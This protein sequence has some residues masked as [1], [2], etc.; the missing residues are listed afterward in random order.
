MFKKLFLLLFILLLSSCAS[1]IKREYKINLP[2]V[3]AGEKVFGV[4]IRPEVS[5]CNRDRVIELNPEWIRTSI[6]WAEVEETKGTYTWNINFST[7]LE[8]LNTINTKVIV[9]IKMTPIWARTDSRSCS[10]IREEN[11]PDFVNFI[12]QVLIKYPTIKYIEIWNEQDVEIGVDDYYGCWGDHTE[13]YYGGEYYATIINSVYTTLKP[14]YLDVQFIY[15]GLANPIGNYLEGSLIAGAKFDILS[16]HY[17][18]W[19]SNQDKTIKDEVQFLRDVLK[20]Y[21]KEVPI[22]LT[23]TSLLCAEGATYCDQDFLIAQANYVDKIEQ[24][25][26]E[27]R[28]IGWIW[29]ALPATGWNNSGLLF[30]DGIPKP[31]YYRLKGGE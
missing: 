3:I 27:E 18:S 25:V 7:D 23:E 22:I 12:R 20:K 28:L 19:F 8:F 10:R 17:Y 4:E 21:N 26:R 13:L 2:V 6:N 9:V 15:G 14:L 29:Y 11:I 1:I 5:L 24:E 31:A 16:F 30:N